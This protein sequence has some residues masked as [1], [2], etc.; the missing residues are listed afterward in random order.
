MEGG[1]VERALPRRQCQMGGLG[2]VTFPQV[3][4]YRERE[5]RQRDFWQLPQHKPT[6]EDLRY[7][8]VWG[9]QA[10]WAALLGRGVARWEHGPQ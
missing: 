4:E 10:I 1:M 6:P 9:W 5:G 3:E 8:A 7:L 2:F